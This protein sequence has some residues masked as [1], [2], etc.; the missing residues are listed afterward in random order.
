MTSSPCARLLVEN[1]GNY[2]TCNG[3][4]DLMVGTWSYQR[5]VYGMT[6]EHGYP[7]YVRYSHTQGI[8]LVTNNLDQVSQVAYHSSHNTRCCHPADESPWL[9]PTNKTLTC[10]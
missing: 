2:G 10:L 1:E 5:P 6:N 4:Y 3:V 7:R 9:K 8:W